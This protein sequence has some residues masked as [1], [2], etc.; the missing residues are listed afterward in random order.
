MLK[1][2]LMILALLGVLCLSSCGLFHKSCNCPHFSRVEI[3]RKT[4]SPV[5]G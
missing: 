2:K 3:S 5:L 1:N 4:N